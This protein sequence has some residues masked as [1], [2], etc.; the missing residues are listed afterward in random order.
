LN[1]LSSSRTGTGFVI[2]NSL[3]TPLYLNTCA[4]EILFHPHKP[5]RTKGFPDQLATKIRS[6]VRNSGADGTISVCPEFQSGRRRYVCRLFTLEWP[7]S[8]TNGTSVGL[9]L[10]RRRSAQL[11]IRHLCRKHNLSPRECQAV[12]LLMEGLANKEIAARML[13]SPNTLKVFFRLAMLKMG[14]TSRSG[15]MSKFI[16]GS[17]ETL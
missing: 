12:E 11:S 17:S 14:A 3:L 1:T 7:G 5:R 16:N 8:T 13:I 2:L 4:V 15:M 6:M 9:L 10:E